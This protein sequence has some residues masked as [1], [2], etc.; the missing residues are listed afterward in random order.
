VDRDERVL[1]TTRRKDERGPLA[2][3]IE[4][5]FQDPLSATP[6]SKQLERIQIIRDQASRGVDR[7]RGVTVLRRGPRSRRFDRA[8]LDADK[9]DSCAGRPADQNESAGRPNARATV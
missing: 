1:V 3:P 4:L 2:V 6:R 5:G 9:R 7:D 8:I